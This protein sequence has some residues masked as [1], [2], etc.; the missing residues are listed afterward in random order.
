MGKFCD[1]VKLEEDKKQLILKLNNIETS[2]ITIRVQD[3]R[4]L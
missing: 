1:K 2:S 3:I 4:V